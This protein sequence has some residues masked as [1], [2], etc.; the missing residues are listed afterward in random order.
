MRFRTASIGV[1]A[2]ASTAQAVP[3]NDLSS[4]GGDVSRSYLGRGRHVLIGILDGG[5]DAN[6]PALRGSVVASRDFSGSGTADDDNSG[7]GH[8][9]GLASLYVGHSSD[10]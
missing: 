2:L 1:L 5:V 4:V 10:F 7:V 9:T 3:Q 8:A 6:H